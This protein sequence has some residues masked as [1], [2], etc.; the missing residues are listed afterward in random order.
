MIRAAVSVPLEPNFAPVFPEN[1]IERQI[2]ARMLI[3]GD[4]TQAGHAWLRKHKE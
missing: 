2:G 4:I 1:Q 3:E